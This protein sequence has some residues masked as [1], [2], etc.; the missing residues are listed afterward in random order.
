LGWIWET[1][2]AVIGLRHEVLVANARKVK[3]INQN[4]RKNDRADAHTLA[5]LARFDPEALTPRPAV[6]RT[7]VIALDEI[8]EGARLVEARTSQR[9]AVPK[10]LQ[11]ST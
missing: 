11:L 7:S 1:K 6:R 9:T 5:R 10:L 8:R 4:S 3:A 2:R